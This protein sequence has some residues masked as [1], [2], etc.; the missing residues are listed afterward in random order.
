MRVGFAKNSIT[1][2]VGV[3]LCGFG[4]F[5]L[6]HSVGVRDRL[7]AR[8]MAIEHG[9]VRATLVT[10]D[11]IGVTAAMTERVRGLVAEHVGPEAA[12]GLLICCSHTH[13]GPSTGPYVG[14]GEADAV[15][16]ETLPSRIATA[17]VRAW[18][19]LEACPE[20]VE[21]AHAEVPCEGIGINREYERETPALE[22]A[23]RDDWRPAKPELTD[24]TC[25]VVTARAEGRLLGFFSYFG[26]HPVVCCAETRYIHGDYAGV[27]TNLL[28][29]EHPGSV[30]LFVQGAQGDVNTCVVHKPEAESLLALDVIAGRY[31]GA[32]RAGLDAAVPF[33]V[34]GIAHCRKAV[35][36]TRREY[37]LGQLRGTLEEHES[38]LHALDATDGAGAELRMDTVWAVALR[39]IISQLDA[40][41][42]TGGPTDVAGMRIGPVAILGSGFE[43]FQAIKNDV[44][45]RAAGPITLVAGLTNDS[46]GYAPDRTMAKQGGYAA[47]FV[48]FLTSK[49]PYANIHDELVEA[50]LGVDAA[51]R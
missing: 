38:R 35:C 14:W 34:D 12:E 15:Y 11:L 33:A 42:D 47:D 22:A 18:E 5:R 43:T 36:F 23:L 8:A 41:E 39:R 20:D 6:R 40:G 1:P 10:C 7:W 50:L 3:E 27:A 13:S 26:C 37:D 25:H 51:L 48:P 19:R 30:G 16:C 17:C 4:P 9:G 24:T 21:L 32:L 31:A 46:V 49:L 2:R 28:E 44:V 45:E 29:R